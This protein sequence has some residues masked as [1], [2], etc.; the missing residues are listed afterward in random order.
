[1]FF[2]FWTCVLVPSHLDGFGE[3][4]EVSHAFRTG[5]PS[6]G[7]FQGCSFVF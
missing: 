5:S 6:N 7:R 3:Q 1:M 2:S 4:E